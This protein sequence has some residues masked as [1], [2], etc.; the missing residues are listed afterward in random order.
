[1]K[2]LLAAL[3]LSE[4]ASEGEAM[5]A[6]S[7]LVDFQTA[8]LSLTGKDSP[9]EALAVLQAF[10]A[11]HEQAAALSTQLEALKKEKEKAEFDAVIQEGLK[12]SKLTPAMVSSDWMKSQTVASLKAYL[13][14]AVKTL[15]TPAK[16]PRTDTQE[17]L[18][19]LS[20]ED[21]AV[22]ELTKADVKLMAASRKRHGGHVP[23]G[24]YLLPANAVETP[25]AE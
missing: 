23:R 10:K 22:A 16:P 19:E 18:G 2:H 25:A 8:A 12:Q 20:A 9:A 15:P 14:V 21:L 5:T 1:M 3:R 17:V 24:P 11:G 7:R 4:T 13:A 6:A